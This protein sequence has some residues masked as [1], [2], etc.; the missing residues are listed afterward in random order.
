MKEFGSD[1]NFVPNSFFFTEDQF[2][3]NYYH[4][5]ANGR[6]AIQHLI[7]YKNW[8]RIWI[9]EYFCYEIVN[10]IK[11]TGINVVMYADSPG[12]NDDSIIKHL[13]F[14]ISDVLLRMN[15]FGMRSFRDNSKIPVEVIEDHSHD[16]SG[17]WAKNSNADWCI[18]SLRKTIPI[19]EGGIL[20]SPKQHKM[21]DQPNQTNENNKLVEKRWLAMKLKQEYLQLKTD[22]KKQFRELFIQT[23]N[24]FENLPLSGL[25]E[26]CKEYLSNF[27]IQSW[28]QQKITNWKILAQIKSNQ[29]QLLL[30][31]DKSCNIFS[32]VF[33]M[34]SERKRELVK[35]NLIQNNLFPAILWALP[36][37]SSA[38]ASKFSTTMLSIP[39]DGRFNKEDME[40]MKNK[41]ESALL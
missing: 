27:D 41:L 31:E 5:Y 1:F 17:I 35:K 37:N 23:E 32:F 19:P 25:T 40:E 18:A 14:K 24:D 8:Q 36:D 15:F 22:N 7:L 39:C 20:W 21:P 9:P 16:F 6:Q 30:P 11:S 28:N 2:Q 10:A 12:L 38:C 26:D 34:E 13:P 33:L 29:L 4:L 3:I